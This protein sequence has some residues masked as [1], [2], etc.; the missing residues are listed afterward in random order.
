MY[1]QSQRKKVDGWLSETDA[2]I[3]ELIL[4]QQSD[5][6]IIGSVAEIGLHH[7]KSF[8][9]LCS[10][11]QPNEKAYGIDIFESQT[12][13]LDSSG[14]GNKEQLLEHLQRF[15]CDMSQ[16]ILDERL[17]ELVKASEIRLSAGE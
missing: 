5:L 9:L 11:L 3:F 14:R 16:I 10:F 12:L 13:N 17:S 2:R 7:G 8:I 1:G 15:D 6:G 4:K